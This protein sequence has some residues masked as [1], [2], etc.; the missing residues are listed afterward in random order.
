MIRTAAS[1]PLTRM[2]ADRA[3]VALHAGALAPLAPGKLLTITNG[4]LM[5]TIAP[6]AGGRIA[7]IVNHGRSLLVE[8]APETA[9]MIAW[10]CYPMVPWAGRVRGGRFNFQ[11][12]AHVLRLNL[13]EHAIH[14][15]AFG[16]PWQVSQQ[17]QNFI[18]MVVAL[19][20]DERW[21]FGGKAHQRI[22]AGDGWLKLELSVQAGQRAMP[23]TIGWHPWFKKPDALEF[24]PARMYPRDDQGIATLPPME[25]TEGPW[26]DCFINH[27][28][29]LLHYPDQSLRM[30][31]GC[32]HWVVYDETANATCVEP[33]SG[34]P[35]AFNLEQCV[36]Q[37][38]EALQR[39]CLIEFQASID[40]SG[41]VGTPS[42]SSGPR[43]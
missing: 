14:G 27:H 18:E 31:S 10:G 15:V 1:K 43:L 36:L 35:D 20:N 21:P 25:P 23:A 5:V 28:P 12:V 32:T 9:A 33:Q 11:G 3:T 4:P 37:P 41:C 7:Q 24:S 34:P 13:G 19:P 39:S 16:M 30:T 29:A 40:G 26:D 17:G 8:Y 6:E 42:D 38:G 2:G 22:E